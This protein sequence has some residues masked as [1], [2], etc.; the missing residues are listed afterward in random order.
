MKKI[1][2]A[3]AL[4]LAVGAYAQKPAVKPKTAVPAKPAVV[5]PLKNQNDSVSYAIGAMVANFYKQQGV[6]HL[7]SSL[8][9]RAVSDIYSN[10]P[11]L[12]N[13]N[14][15]NSVV[16]RYLNPDLSKHVAESEKF[17]AQN[18]KKAGVKTSPSGLQYE[19]IS[20]GKGTKPTATDTVTVHYQGTLINGTE[21]DNSYKRGEPISFPLGG[22]I[23][24][25][26][27]G[28]Q[29]MSVGSKYRFYIP[30]QLGYGMNG[31][32]PIPGG[33]ALIFEVELLKVNGKE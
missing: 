1:L 29:Y 24:G 27:E 2:V 22:V 10:K 32:G 8:V 25:W 9:A 26:T 20:E 12:L 31:S 4:M 6:K 19:V 14:Q 23:P 5:K 7:N 11:A 18:Q 17:L 16:M 13:E 3:G 21:F 33:A 15:C 30:Y 28:L